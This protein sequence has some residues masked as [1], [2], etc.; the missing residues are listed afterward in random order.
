MVKLKLYFPE[1]WVLYRVRVGQ[2]WDLHEIWKME[3][4][5][6]P[7]SL[8]SSSLDT[9]DRQR[10]V[11]VGSTVLP[12]SSAQGQA[13]PPDCSPLFNRDPRFLKRCVAVDPERIV[14]YSPPISSPFSLPLA[15]GYAWFLE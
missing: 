11:T 3:L 7:L 13:L 4:E 15:A 14:P 10:Q 12:L 1:F 6:Q 2:N 5:H 9:S 8:R